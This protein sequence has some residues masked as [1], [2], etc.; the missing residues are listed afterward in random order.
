MVRPVPSSVGESSGS[1]ASPSSSHRYVEHDAVQAVS[2]HCDAVAL[3]V[4]CCPATGFVGVTVNV[5]RGLIPAA[6]ADAAVKASTMSARPNTRVQSLRMGVFTVSPSREAT[7]GELGVSTSSSDDAPVAALTTAFVAHAMPPQCALGTCN[8]INPFGSRAVSER[9]LALRPR[10][11]TGLP[12]SLDL[13]RCLSL[14]STTPV[15]T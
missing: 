1:V 8:L 3:N 14:C 10:L 2:K 11:A 7:V 15:G 6:D 13:L 5:A 9:P 12:L 4:T